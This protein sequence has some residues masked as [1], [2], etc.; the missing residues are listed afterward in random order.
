MCNCLIKS[1][2][3]F[4]NNTKPSF[5]TYKIYNGRGRTVIH[6]SILHTTVMH[7]IVIHISIL[8]ITVMHTTVMCSMV[9]YMFV[10]NTA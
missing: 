6:T 4:N 8:H 2:H 3:T 5:N 9:V 7:T 1:C 10:C